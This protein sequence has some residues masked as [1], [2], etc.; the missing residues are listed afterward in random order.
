MR[1]HLKELFY[2]VVKKVKETIQGRTRIS[3]NLACE[4][5]ISLGVWLETRRNL[6][7]QAKLMQ[8]KKSN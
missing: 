4:E 7:S 1:K 5:A 2:Q 8:S 3:K 6:E